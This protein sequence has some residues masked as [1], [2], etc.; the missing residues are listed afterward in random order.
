MLASVQKIPRKAF[1]FGKIKCMQL[2]QK[3]CQSADQQN[4]KGVWV[5]KVCDYV[6]ACNSLK[7]NLSQMKVVE[8]FESRPQEGG[9]LCG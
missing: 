2:H 5:E 6:S 7:G 8:D 1:G 9:L 4:A 3:E